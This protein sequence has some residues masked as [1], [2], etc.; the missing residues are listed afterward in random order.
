MLC[1]DS[2]QRVEDNM[3]VKKQKMTITINGVDIAEVQKTRRCK[4]NF[5]SPCVKKMEKIFS[6]V[7]SSKNHKFTDWETHT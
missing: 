3:I 6:C 1:Y 4:D 5:V 7:C 2:I